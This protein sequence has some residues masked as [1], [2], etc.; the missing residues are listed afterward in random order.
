[1]QIAHTEGFRTFAIEHFYYVYRE[2]VL[3]IFLEN[4]KT[5]AFMCHLVEELATK[6]GVSITRHD[7]GCQFLSWWTGD[8][9]YSEREIALMQLGGGIDKFLTYAEYLR[10]AKLG[11]D[12]FSMM[13]FYVCDFEKHVNA[14]L[15][16]QFGKSFDIT[17]LESMA[18][19]KDVIFPKLKNVMR[20]GMLKDIMQNNPGAK[21]YL[22]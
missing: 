19:S 14:S 12:E 16:I 5:T 17:Y 9:E 8:W 2:H 15:E 3:K 7:V 21:I 11:M 13:Q 18:F 4:S 1:M 6:N 20:V 10:L 22:T